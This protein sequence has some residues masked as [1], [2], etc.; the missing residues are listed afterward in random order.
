MRRAV[1]AGFAY[2]A[3]VFAAGFLLG[4]IRTLMLAPRVGETAAVLIELP[5]MLAISWV[6]CGIVLRR[7]DVPAARA[8]RFV[9]GALAFALL[10][11]AE[12]ALAA[13]FGETPAL[14]LQ[15]LQTPAGA[16]GLAGQAA[17]AVIPLVR[18]ARA[19]L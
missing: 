14:Y 8:A 5:A 13:A 10:M 12:A 1:F 17:F 19:A 7:L 15:E 2:F 3:I 16:L 9:M 11:A 18:R 4:T 6:A